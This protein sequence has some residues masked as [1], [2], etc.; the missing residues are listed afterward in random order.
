MET[1]SSLLNRL[2]EKRGVLKNSLVPA[3]KDFIY[4][5]IIKEWN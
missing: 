3:S 2:E 1:R 5:H 4:D